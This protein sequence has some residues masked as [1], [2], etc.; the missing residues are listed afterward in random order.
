LS[1]ESEVIVTYGVTE[2]HITNAGI[3][4]SISTNQVTDT[5]LGTVGPTGATGATGSK[6]DPGIS[7][8][9]VAETVAALKAY[10]T[11]EGTV[12][13]TEAGRKGVFVWDSN[14]SV[15]LH[16]ADG[17]E[18]DLVAPISTAT[19]A[20]R[21]LYKF[22]STDIKSAFY[23]LIAQR[24]GGVCVLKKVRDTGAVN[25]FHV[26]TQLGAT[27]PEFARWICSNH[28]N[29]TNAEGALR[30]VN[31][32]RALLYRTTRQPMPPLVK[33]IGAHDDDIFNGGKIWRTT[34]GTET[35][36]FLSTTLGGLL[37]RRSTT[38]GDD[39]Q[40][41]V[42]GVEL[43][44]MRGQAYTN[45]G[46]VKVTITQG[47]TEIPAGDYLVPLT[48]S[49]RIFS[50]RNTS[51]GAD[52]GFAHVPLALLDPVLEYVVKLEVDTTNPSGGRMYQGGL[53]GWAPGWKT[54]SGQYGMVIQAGSA[55]TQF[56]QRYEN[57]RV[58]YACRGATRIDWQAR[59]RTNRGI[60]NFEIYDADGNAVT[61]VLASFD[62]Y[63]A[64]AITAMITVVTGL[65]RGD[66]FLH[67]I[68]SGAK[69]ASSS[70]AS[71]DHMSVDTIDETQ[72]GD[73]ATQA[74]DLLDA[75]A[76]AT[77]AI[78]GTSDYIGY[79]TSNERVMLIR[80][81]S[82]GA[83][84]AG[85]VGGVHGN[86]DLNSVVYR[87]DGATIDWNSASAGDFW[88]GSQVEVASQTTLKFPSDGTAAGTAS[89]VQRFTAAGY[90][91]DLT[92]T[93]SADTVIGPLYCLMHTF[94]SD[95]AGTPGLGGGYDR[96]TVQPRGE[97]TYAPG[98]S[99]TTLPVAPDAIATWNNDY[100]AVG[101]LVNNNEVAAVFADLDA[102]NGGRT[103]FISDNA[104]GGSPVPRNKFYILPF[105]KTGG[106]TVP[107]GRSWNI[108]SF[109][110]VAKT[111]RFGEL[112]E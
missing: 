64:S 79:D 75:S 5:I 73:P 24:G 1:N 46:T 104:I 26:F 58:V 81:T 69:N 109:W 110:G 68:V 38:I 106:V 15:G 102:D 70:S 111:A 96:V 63:S 29:S 71:I 13:L 18:R 99:E 33:D 56:N 16:Q 39:V 105:S 93:L 9:S 31:C 11:S 34:D 60:V 23:S 97:F 47:G 50:L 3:E 72:A 86:E 66:Y 44:H 40:Y 78:V 19:G 95:Y 107:A 61:P 42:R 98:A 83:G 112:V 100:V 90:D 25:E 35:G 101:W 77:S 85:F 28:A 2:A 12:L 80:K 49:D 65:P 41:T 76:L 54:R 37:L 22:G 91:F 108:K 92:D 74:F 6:G 36:T 53:V 20:W 30:M 57:E 103:A 51:F 4:I 48:G 59:S 52:L 32:T 10:G 55:T 84:A 88:I 62:L 87:V 7:G 94:P 8:L 17:D 43:L 45:G 14:V 89:Y 82:E 27:S 21:R 67:V